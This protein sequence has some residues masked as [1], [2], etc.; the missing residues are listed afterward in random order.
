MWVR[1]WTA[2][3]AA[4]CFL[5]QRVRFGFAREIDGDDTAGTT[6]KSREDL[7]LGGDGEGLG[8][9]VMA[10]EGLMEKG[11]IAGSDDYLKV[12]WLIREL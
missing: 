11:G 6:E 2:I 8:R 1:K 9:G 4:Q 3:G 12:I 5:L 10:P 7:F